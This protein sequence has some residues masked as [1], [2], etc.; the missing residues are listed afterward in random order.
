MECTANEESPEINQQLLWL[1]GV[2]AIL[3]AVF[4]LILV[5]IKSHSCRKRRR[6]AQRPAKPG[7]C[8]AR[9]KPNQGDYIKNI[10]SD[11]CSV[12]CSV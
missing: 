8:F 5:V 9:L 10:Y 4:T 6:K 1:I 3:S 11:L 2:L 12:I 7:T